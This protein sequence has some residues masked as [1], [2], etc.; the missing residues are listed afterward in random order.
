MNISK[1][2]AEIP[3]LLMAATDSPWID[4]LQKGRWCKNTPWRLKSTALSALPADTTSQLNI[5][6]HY[7]HA[8]GM[9]SAQIGV[10][11]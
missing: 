7:R 2:D 3:G 8:L 9:D 1:T 5:L 11:E 4:N 10:L 6:R